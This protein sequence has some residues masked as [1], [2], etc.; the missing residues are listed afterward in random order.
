MTRAITAGSLAS[1]SKKENLSLAESFLSVDAILVVD[2]SGS[3]AANDAPGG[4][5]RYEAAEKELRQLQSSM[6]GKVAVVAFSSTVQF[7]PGGI[8]PR[9]GGGTDM[10][11]ALRFVQPADGCAKIVLISDGQ[12]DSES[13]TLAV[14]REFEHRIDTVYIG[15]ESGF[16]S[17]G[18]AGRAFLEKL[19][20]AT[21]GK[22]MKSAAPGLLREQV[23]SLLL[24]ARV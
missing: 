13:A 7:C 19:A 1:I 5:S 8:P 20:A 21:G 18:P 16:G 12:P 11:G 23:E 24:T 2:M 17:Y 15:P 6:P 4:I 10:A 14:A 3:M 9:L 22:A